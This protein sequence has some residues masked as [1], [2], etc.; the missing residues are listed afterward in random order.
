[1]PD[2]R[3][4]VDETGRV[5][6]RGAYICR[7]GDCGAT[8]IEKGL[9]GRALETRIP[10]ELRTQLGH[11]TTTRQAMTDTRLT[12]DEGGARGEE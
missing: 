5:A 1:M 4:V 11:R 3:V 12:N 8:A 9:L 2:G 7:D 10:D 6:G